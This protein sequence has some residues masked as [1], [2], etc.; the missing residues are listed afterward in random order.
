MWDVYVYLKRPELGD[1]YLVI[2]K[3]VTEIV[4]R[5][6]QLE[7]YSTNLEEIVEERT[8]QLKASQEKMLD[9]EEET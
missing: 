2:G 3:D 9:L 4:H 8:A 6:K 1:L 5:Q 7:T